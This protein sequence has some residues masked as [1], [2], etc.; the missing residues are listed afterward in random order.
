MAK[1]KA[2]RKVAWPDLEDLGDGRYRDLRDGQVYEVVS[3][4]LYDSESV[5]VA[6][7]HPDPANP[8][9]PHALRM[10][11]AELEVH[12]KELLEWHPALAAL[13]TITDL[14]TRDA[15]FDALLEKAACGGL[16][17]QKGGVI[18]GEVRRGRKDPKKAARNL[19]IM[20]AYEAA[21]LRG[22]THTN[23]CNRIG[24]AFGL[25]GK[26]VRDLVNAAKKKRE[27]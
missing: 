23:A 3:G 2:K 21:I 25:T 15:A 16:R 18:S 12:L 17:S 19:E 7:R 5:L 26:R 8:F 27:A 11:R 9:D 10:K 4:D 20:E 1:R 24:K 6:Y 14:P 13:D 22:Q